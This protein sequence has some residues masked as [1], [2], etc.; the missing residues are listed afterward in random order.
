MAN[1]SPDTALPSAPANNG[2]APSAPETTEQVKEEAEEKIEAAGDV[3]HRI[4]DWFA[5]DALTLPTGVQAALIL[6]AIVFGFTL[7]QVLRPLAQ[8]LIGGD[9]ESVWRRQLMR[10]IESLL[11][12]TLSLIFLALAGP[13]ASLL[14]LPGDILEIA[15]SLVLAWIVIRLITSTVQNI[16]WSRVLTTIIWIIAALAIIGWLDPI[17]AFL[18][19]LALEIGDTRISLY[20]VLKAGII[21]ALLLWA[22][23]K[24]ANLIQGRVESI[25]SLTPSMQTLI[26]QTVRFALIVIAIVFALDTIGVDL[27]AFAVFSGALG[28]GIGFGLQKI[29]GNIVSGIILLLDRSVKPGDVIEIVDTYGEVKSLGARYTSVKTRDGTEHLIPNEDLIVNTVIN[30]SHT[31][32]LIRIKA[33]V[34]VS[35]GADVDLAMQLVLESCQEVERVLANPAP[36]V[37]LT[38]FGDSSVDL[39]ARFWVKDPGGGVSNV[40]S[41]VYL[42]VWHKFKEH[43]VEIPFPQRDL[44]IKSGL[45]Q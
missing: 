13:I 27:T 22:A 43:G 6:T 39:E 29:V 41:E 4:A 31:D 20:M 36:T 11:G 8:R 15:K 21:G 30:W 40:R 44:H 16:Y 35:Y 9:P 17:T 45:N 32:P 25:S 3:L 1:D 19:S 33:P 37:L 5:N 7:A 26:G 10:S 18:D 38:G 28:V 23:V 14:S 42:K 2:Q 12:P 34:G 24:G